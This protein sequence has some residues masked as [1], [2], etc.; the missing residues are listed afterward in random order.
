LKRLGRL[1]ISY[2]MLVKVQY[3]KDFLTPIESVQT[4][5]DLRMKL[6]KE[7]IFKFYDFEKWKLYQCGIELNDLNEQLVK[8]GRMITL[9][10]PDDEERSGDKSQTIFTDAVRFLVI[11]DDDGLKIHEVT[12]G[13]NNTIRSALKYYIFGPQ[14]IGLIKSFNLD[15]PQDKKVECTIYDVNKPGKICI[16][17]S[18]D[19]ATPYVTL[20]PDDGSDEVPLKPRPETKFYSESR[21]KSGD[22]LK[23]RD[24]YFDS[25]E[26]M[27]AAN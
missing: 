5:G 4:V 26:N 8:N 15:N 9:V 22:S 2:R 14:K 12:N 17:K 3:Q 10:K 23:S 19:E 24:E 13:L 1:Y 20:I 6:S 18:D 16:W 27:F 25:I 7:S 21:L 11:R